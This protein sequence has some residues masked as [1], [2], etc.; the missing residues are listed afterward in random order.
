MSNAT[1]VPEIM[2]EGFL[3]F[4][5][6]IDIKKNRALHC[7]CWYDAMMV[8]NRHTLK[9]IARVYIIN[10]KHYTII[11]IIQKSLLCISFSASDAA[12]CSSLQSLLFLLLLPSISS[13]NI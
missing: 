10:F 9:Y 6:S 4:V 5:L 11:I 13:I 3:Y 12:A 2:N 7:R 8:N 1:N